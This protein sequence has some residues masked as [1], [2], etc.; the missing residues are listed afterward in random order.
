MRQVEFRIL[1]SLQ[2]TDGERS[3]ELRRPKPRALLAVLLLH[4]NQVVSADRLIDA[5]W[6]DSPPRSAANTLQ[7]YV[8]WLRQALAP[9]PGAP[10]VRTQD[11]GYVLSLDPEQID[12]RRFERMVGEAR[13]ARAAGKAER[14]AEVLGRALALWRGPALADFGYEQFAGIEAA[15]LEELRLFA[16]EE[17]A[18]A[19]LALGRHAQLTGPLQALVDGHPLR[20]PLWGLLMLALYRCGRQADALRAFQAA[21]RALAEELG[22]APCPALCRLEAEILVQAPSLEWTAVRSLPTPSRSQPSRR[23]CPSR[24]RCRSGRSRPDTSG[25]GISASSLTDA[26]PRSADGAC[27]AV[28]LS[29]RPGAGKTGTAGEVAPAAHAEGA[30][31]LYRSRDPDVVLRDQRVVEALGSGYS[32]RHPSGLGAPHREADPPGSASGGMGDGCQ[33][34]DVIGFPVREGTAR[35]GRELMADH[36]RPQASAD[37]RAPRPPPGAKARAPPCPPSPRSL[38]R[39][40]AGGLPATVGLLLAWTRSCGILSATEEHFVGRREELGILQNALENARAARPRVVLVHGSAGMGKSALLRR[41]LGGAGSGAVLRASGDEGETALTYGVVAQLLAGLPEPLPG[42]LSSLRAGAGPSPDPLTVGA[43]LVEM[44][45]VLQDDGPMILVVDDA[46]WADTPSLHALVFAIRRLRVDRVL[47]V[48]VARDDALDSMPSGLHRLLATEVGTEVPLGGLPLLDLRRLASCLGAGRLPTAAVQRLARH[49]GGNPLHVRALLAELPASGLFA[50]DLPAPRSFSA[51]VQSRLASCPP[52][53]KTLVVAASVLGLRCG[54]GLAARLGSVADPLVALEAA[55]GA[56]LLHTAATP[57][58]KE[59][60]FVHP[61]VRAAVYHDVAPTRRA[62]FH[63]RAATLVEDEGSALRH[64]AAASPADDAD[65]A[66]DVGAYALREARRGAWAAAAAAFLSSAR[67]SP[68]N[69]E[70]ERRFIEAVQCLLVA[71][72][73]AQAAALAEELPRFSDSPRRRC[74]LGQLA[75]VAGRLDEAERLLL[76]AW[77]GADRGADPESAA[78]I[79]TQLASIYMKRCRGSE[80]VEWA[81]RAL[82]AATDLSVGVATPP[83]LLVLGLAA[84]GRPEEGLALVDRLPDYEGEPDARRVEWLA[85][86]GTVRMWTDDLRGAKDDLSTVAE[87]CRRRGPFNLGVIATYYLSETEYRLGEWDEAVVHGEVAASAAEDADQAWVLAIPHAV[88]TF[89]LAARGVWERAEAHARAAAEAAA[90]LGAAGDTTWAAVASA[91]LALAAGDF[92]GA[93]AALVSLPDLAAG[94]AMEE[95]NIQ[96]WRELYAEALVR[97]GRLEEAEQMLAPLEVLAAGR[98]R[99]SSLA[100]AARVRGMLEGARG[101]DGD[102]HAAFQAGLVHAAQVE[103]PFERALLEDAYGRFLRR[104]GERRQ[105]RER[106]GGAYEVYLRLGARPFVE[107]VERE[108]AACGLSPARR[109]PARHLEL[110]PQELAVARLVAAGKTN[111]EVAAELVV[112]AK[113]VGYHLGN[114]YTKLGVSSR[115]QMAARFTRSTL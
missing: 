24:A 77:E 31:G 44:L 14:A 58:V 97:L 34:R 113:T 37:A 86:R 84:A 43:A 16:L 9:L 53:A 6:G 7:G 61:L 46:Q 48:L 105:A 56:G 38:G 17:H 41:F 52:E 4:P 94:G 109:S 93:A 36:T 114:V 101:R 98:G 83:W 3:V 57:T 27:R 50:D 76:G 107:R 1:G 100:G 74:A 68:G 32:A 92:A 96:P 54:L 69:I 12:A 87:I 72:E 11:P 60:S 33:A 95:P 30:V 64:L 91:R 20:E 21:R 28:L 18:Q 19:E 104:A 2:V 88:A 90:A 51:L 65:L 106:L 85:G 45:G 39:Q 40:E 115:T 47:A 23:E 112:S 29:G 49:T 25:G 8:S 70:R 73:Y 80:T 59:I 67:L 111:R 13:D 81:R 102:A 99:R 10:R 71:G 22:I 89:P 63:T 15:R 110:T 42:T 108:L 66:A 79:A 55:V 82:N 35:P 78:R 5:L 103:M 62:A 75:F 26:R